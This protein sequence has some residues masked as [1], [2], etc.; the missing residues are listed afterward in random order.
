MAVVP[1]CQECQHLVNSERYEAGQV[2]TA[3][4]VSVSV[5]VTVTGLQLPSP[6]LPPLPAVMVVVGAST[7]V[8]VSVAV[9]CR[10]VVCSVLPAWLW[11]L[12]SG[13]SVWSVKS[14]SY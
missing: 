1:L 6:P 4:T 5:T 7:R 13:V 11:P 12:A 3:V 14:V 8:T 9:E 10:V 2:R